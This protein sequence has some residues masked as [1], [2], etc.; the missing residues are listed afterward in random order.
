[1][2]AVQGPLREESWAFT[3]VRRIRQLLGVTSLF[4]AVLRCGVGQDNVCMVWIIGLW[5]V[6]HLPLT[7]SGVFSGNDGPAIK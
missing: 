4:V 2:A 7:A 3:P 6:N 5:G 1:M